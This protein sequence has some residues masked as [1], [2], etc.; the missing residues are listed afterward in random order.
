VFTSP[1]TQSSYRSVP[2]ADI[3]FKILRD[4]KR[5]MKDNYFVNT[6]TM[7]LLEPRTFRAYYRNIILGD[8]GL[9]RCLHFHGLRHSFATRLIATGTDPKTTSKILGHSK[10]EMT[11]NLYVHPSD[12]NKKAAVNKSFKNLFK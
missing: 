12:E 4:Y 3:L 2:I 1:K 6:G 5:I 7:N 11:M 8:I 10:V 9:S